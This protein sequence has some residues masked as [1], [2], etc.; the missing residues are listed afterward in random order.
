MAKPM[1]PKGLAIRDAI[2]L[3]PNKSNIELA[4]I[5]S[6]SFGGEVKPSDVANQKTAMKKK[7]S[8]EDDSDTQPE[9]PLATPTAAPAPAAATTEPP[10][11]QEPSRPAAAPPVALAPPDPV[12]LILKG[13]EFLALCGSADR[14]V[15]ILR[16]LQGL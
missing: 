12:S 1:S 16:A 13:K 8:A 10:A 11:P 4:E 14:A 3:H 5:A 6:R 2:R 7:E 15:A 9:L